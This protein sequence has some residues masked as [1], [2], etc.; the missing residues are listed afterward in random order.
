MNT[1]Y[2]QK[3]FVKKLLAGYV[4]VLIL[5][6]SM[7]YVTYENNRIKELIYDWIWLPSF[8]ISTQVI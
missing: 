1:P 3:S 5:I 8:I 7:F 4:P 6:G 2:E